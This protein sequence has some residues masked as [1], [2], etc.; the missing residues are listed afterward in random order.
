MTVDQALDSDFLT[1]ADPYRRELLAHC[2]RMMGSIHDAEDQVQETFIRAWRGFDGFRGQSS[3]R[4][5]LYRIA[6]NTCLTALEG[7]A[8]RPLPTGLGAPSSDPS[9]ELVERSEIPWLEPI[10]DSSL[11]DVNDPAVMV[12]QRDSVRLALIAAL[13]HLSARQRAVLVLRDVLQWKAAEVA[14]ALDTTT[15]AVNSVLQR[16]RAQITS[17]AP[18]E[19]TLIE[20]SSGEART[21]LREYVRSFESYD[22]DAIVALFTR[23]AVWEMPPFEGWYRGPEAIGQLIGNKCPADGPG[24]MRLLPTSANGQPAFGLYMRQADGIHHAFQ[25][26]VLDVTESGISHVTCFFDLS[27]FPRFG[28]PAEL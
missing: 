14:E 21:M 1:L 7:R 3:F 26:H 24:A 10:A 18:T 4:T 15:T 5:W 8:K 17:I 22:V 6:T 23:D 27:L 28:L 16:A 12:V 20:P 2:Y 25:L 13:Q 9:D 19:E 11:G